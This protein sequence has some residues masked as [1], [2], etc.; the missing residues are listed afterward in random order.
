MYFLTKKHLSRRKLLRGTGVALGLPLLESMVPAG[1][2]RAADVS[3]P[4][5]RLACVYIPHGAVQAS[6]E[7]SNIGRNFAFSP[8]LKSLEPFRDHITIVSGLALPVAYA[9]DP[10]AGGHH[11]R[12]SQCWLTCVAPGTG[13]SP[14]SMDQ[15]AASHIGQDFTA[16]PEPRVQAAVRIVAHECHIV[17][18]V[19]N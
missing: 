4:K 18:C 5:S 2:A 3:T 16:T 11:N 8:T 1:M 6:W 9:G 13:P 19:G 15:V 7:P 12:S 17:T 14:T 10:S